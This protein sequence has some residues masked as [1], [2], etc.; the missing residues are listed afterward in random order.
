MKKDVFQEVKDSEKA[1]AAMER[2]A[3]R[4]KP[5]IMLMSFEFALPS[6]KKG[7]I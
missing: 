3:V 6:G 5:S 4:C 2:E 7:A 1:D